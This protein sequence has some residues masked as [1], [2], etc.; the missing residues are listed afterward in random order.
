MDIDNIP[1]GMD[2]RDHLQTTLQSCD[3]L[4]AVVGPNWLG[5]DKDGHHRIADEADWVRIEIEAAL[6][7]NVPVIPILIDRSRL[8]KPSEL[9]EGLRNFAFRQAAEIDSG[10]DFR[11]HMDRLIRS[12][13]RYLQKQSG[14]PLSTEGAAQNQEPKLGDV[15]LAANVLRASLTKATAPKEVAHPPRIARVITNSPW[16]LAIALLVVSEVLAV[17]S[18]WVVASDHRQLF[19]ALVPF[20]LAAL[21][22]IFLGMRLCGYLRT[23]ND[24]ALASVGIG[25]IGILLIVTVPAFFHLTHPPDQYAAALAWPVILL[26]GVGVVLIA[27]ALITIARSVPKFAA[28]SISFALIILLA[29]WADSSPTSTYLPMLDWRVRSVIIFTCVIVGT[30]ML[31]VMTSFLAVQF[32]R[33]SSVT[34]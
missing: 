31:V 7:K 8:P 16:A 20:P 18:E 12:M 25:V 21:G 33:R 1:V 28:A 17:C 6:A 26:G 9:P 30:T 3:I 2:F 10:L 5:T 22:L 13:D 19:L 14:V 23:C 34:S 11:M 27:A 4:L 32:M 29:A 15:E 24:Y